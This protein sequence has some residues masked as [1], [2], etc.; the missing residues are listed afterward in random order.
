MKSAL[1]ILLAVALTGGF[2][3]SLVIGNAMKA[4]EDEGRVYGAPEGKIVHLC[5]EYVTTDTTIKLLLDDGWRYEGPLYN[6]G[7]NCTVTLW[8]R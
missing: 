7:I 1:S 5:R 4:A 8:T 6:D 2:A 3:Y